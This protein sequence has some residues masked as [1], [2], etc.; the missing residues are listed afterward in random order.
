MNQSG[1]LK[2]ARLILVL[3]IIPVLLTYASNVRFYNLNKKYNISI[4]EAN[5]VCE[6]YNGFIWASSKLGIMRFT[7]DDYRIYNLPYES[8]YVIYVWLAYKD[9]KLYAYTNNGQ[10][11]IYNELYDRFDLFINISEKLKNKKLTVNKIL[12]GPEN[13]LWI[14]SSSGLFYFKNNNLEK[15]VN[16]ETTYLCWYNEKNIFYANEDGIFLLETSSFQ[17]ETY[18]LTPENENITFSEL[19]YDKTKSELW[20]GTVSQGIICLKHNGFSLDKSVINKIPSQPI[21]A[22]EANTDSTLLVGIDGQGIWEINRISKKVLNIY[23][24]DIDDVYSLRGNGVYDIYCDN[25]NRVWVCTYSGGVSFYDQDIPFLQNIRHITNNSNSLVNNEINCVLEDSNGNIWFATN[26]GISRWDVS[27]NKWKSFYHNEQEQAQVFLSLCEDNEGRIWA[28]TY[29]SGVYVLDNKTGLGIEHYSPEKTNGAF[30]P[31]FIFDLYKDSDNDIWI[32]DIK[33]YSAFYRHETGEFIGVEGFAVYTVQEYA[34]GQI[35][36]GSSEGVLLYNKHTGNLKT[37]V[38]NCIVNDMFVMDNS[39]W[40][41]TN[42]EGVIHYDF[43]SNSSEQ[44]SI[45]SDISSNFVSSIEYAQ[46]YFWLGTENGLY[47]MNLNDKSITSFE[48]LDLSNLSFNMNSLNKLRNGKLIWGTNNGALLFDPQLVQI[49][50]PEGRVFY[51][52]LT[53]AGRSIRDTMIYDLKAPLDSLEELILK[54]NQN[55][56]TLELLPIGASEPGSKLSWKLEGFDENWSPATDN[57]ILTYTNLPSGDFTL[58]I[59]MYNNSQDTIINERSIAIYK[60]PP[61]WE[62]WWFR[63]MLIVVFA[64]VIA[65]IFIYYIDKLKKKHSEEKIKFFANTAHD[66][67]TSLTLI[68]APIEALQKEP[69]LSEQA[70]YYLNLVKEQAQRLSS[71]VTKLMDFQKVDVGKEKINLA[72]HDI[73]KLVKNRLKI[74]ESY[75]GKKN[76]QLILHAN[77]ISYITAVDENMIEKVVD[78]LISNAIK[79]SHNNSKVEI[80]LTVNQFKWKFEVIDSGLGITKKAQKQLFKEF[81]RGENAVN[82]KIIGSG[83][84]LLLVKNYVSQHNGNVNCNSQDGVGST[85][86]VEVPYKKVAENHL[87]GKKIKLE[88]GKILTE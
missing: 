39:I 17:S 61:F 54:Y 11:F 31:N 3:L 34:K 83:I 23:K 46:G 57:R 43:D 18:Y 9:K 76:V 69:N 63:F 62:R 27:G 55:T 52:D 10:V 6:D 51:Q 5:E 22:F 84:G 14:A 74:F 49:S 19:Y 26:N 33:G 7:D 30:S 72:M 53:I 77:R 20:V 41:C 82:S 73:I 48:S 13:E 86:T 65:V 71:V 81:Y 1:Y 25:N 28:G 32:A 67:R 15:V 56:I 42:G 29:S 37:L 75:A 45:D 8:A 60:I 36:L 78:N 40:I 2:K 79:Y 87:N 12:I 68:N 88:E 47:R 38:D 64:A 59:R 21:L 35:L 44:Y 24:E 70:L 4:R 58:K 85:F 50:Y 66:I 16:A 80:S